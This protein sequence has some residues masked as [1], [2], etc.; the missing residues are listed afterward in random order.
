MEHVRTVKTPIQSIPTF[1]ETVA[2]LMK[3][4]FVYAFVIMPCSRVVQPENQ[5][6]KFNVDVKPQNEPD[7]LFSLIHKVISQS[8][9]WET[10]LAPRIL[11]GLWHPRFLEHAKKHLPYCRRSHIGESLY[12][13]R[14][15]FWNDCEVFSVRFSVLASADGQKYVRSCSSLTSSLILRAH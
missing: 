6:V 1:A 11:L 13:S 12:L 3:V 10:K 4:C 2:L 8:P 9:E 15:Y 14:N 7:K 5:H